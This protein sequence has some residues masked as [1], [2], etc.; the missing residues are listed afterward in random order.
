MARARISPASRSIQMPPSAS[1]RSAAMS[2]TKATGCPVGR[3]ALGSITRQ[4]RTK[5]MPCASRS[6]RS[7]RSET[8]Q[9]KRFW[10]RSFM[11]HPSAV[12]LP[13][14][15]RPRPDYNKCVAK[16]LAIFAAAPQD[17]FSNRSKIS[18]VH[19]TDT[20]FAFNISTIAGEPRSGTRECFRDDAATDRASPPVVPAAPCRCA[21]PVPLAYSAAAGR[22]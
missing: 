22:S 6:A 12:S 3:G 7:R 20:T 11:G 10:E 17:I 13:T 9:T 19:C 1:A 14:R 15:T 21:R 16:S 4:G 2:M 18:E 5:S 8:R